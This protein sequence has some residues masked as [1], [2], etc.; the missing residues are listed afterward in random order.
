MSGDASHG[1]VLLTP[2][3]WREL[4]KEAKAK[5]T[6]SVDSESGPEDSME[7]LEVPGWS[8][9]SCPGIDTDEETDCSGTGTDS[10]DDGGGKIRP[11]P[12]PSGPPPGP[13]PA[14]PPGPPLAPADH[15]E[16]EEDH[17]SS[18]RPGCTPPSQTPAPPSS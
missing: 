7:D 16:H 13:P 10:S 2:S 11:P 17:P 8:S 9:S 15:S 3:A 4:T 12:G 5:K 6:K 1:G 18:T 14:P